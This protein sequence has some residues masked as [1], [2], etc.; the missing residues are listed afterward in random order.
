M[1]GGIK[2]AAVAGALWSATLNVDV[3]PPAFTTP[4]FSALVASAIAL[5]ASA[6]GTYRAPQNL[7]PVK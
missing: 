6:I 5:L 2:W 7:G 3:L 1:V 4:E